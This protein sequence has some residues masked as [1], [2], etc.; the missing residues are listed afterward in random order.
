MLYFIFLVVA[1]KKI[2]KKIQHVGGGDFLEA[3]TS[4]KY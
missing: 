4:N 3:T 1:E 2:A